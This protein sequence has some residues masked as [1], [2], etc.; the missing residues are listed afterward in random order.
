VTVP[1][2]LGGRLLHPEDTERLAIFAGSASPRLTA[3]IC[4]ELGVPIGKS[5]VL[6][7]SEAACSPGFWHQRA[8]LRIG[9]SVAYDRSAPL[10]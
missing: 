2:E 8:V 5:Q 6:R 3:A 7:F 4:A 9:H 1:A 10:G